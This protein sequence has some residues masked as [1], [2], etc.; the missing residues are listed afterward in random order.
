MGMDAVIQPRVRLFE[1]VHLLLHFCKLHATFSIIQNALTF[2]K[3][4]HLGSRHTA[5][6]LLQPP[7][8]IMET[9]AVDFIYTLVKL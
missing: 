8:D 2:L 5:F 7:L 6:S 9:S 1:L 3:I 4:S